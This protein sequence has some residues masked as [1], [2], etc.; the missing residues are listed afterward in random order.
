[1][2]PGPANHILRLSAAIVVMPKRVVASWHTTREDPS[3][4]WHH[5]RL[6][7]P[8]ALSIV[9]GRHANRKGR[10]AAA[11]CTCLSATNTV[12]QVEQFD[13]SQHL[14]IECNRSTTGLLVQTRSPNACEKKHAVPNAGNC[15]SFE[16]HLLSLLECRADFTDLQHDVQRPYNNYLN[17]VKVSGP[18]PNWDFR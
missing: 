7:L 15:P 10:S 3:R 1:V 18:L 12:G 2:N 17:I 11:R 13:D 4:F 8:I 16:L 14:T 5:G 9:P 6:V